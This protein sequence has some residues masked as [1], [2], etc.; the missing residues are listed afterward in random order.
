MNAREDVYY[1][2]IAVTRGTFNPNLPFT[3]VQPGPLSPHTMLL[4][5]G[6]TQVSPT[7]SISFCPTALAVCASI[8]NLDKWTM[9]EIGGIADKM[10]PKNSR[11]L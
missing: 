2:L 10:P 9:R 7:N 11:K 1:S 3:M 4:G 6:A 8:T 5:V